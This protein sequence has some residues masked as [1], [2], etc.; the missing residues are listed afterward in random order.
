MQKSFWQCF[1]IFVYPEC[2]PVS[3]SKT[4]LIFSEEQ[5]NV[6][7]NA[8][9][10]FLPNCYVTVQVAWIIPPWCWLSRPRRPQL[11]VQ[12]SAI[13]PRFTS[14]QLPEPVMCVKG[15]VRQSHPHI[16]LPAEQMGVAMT[17]CGLC[18]NVCGQYHAVWVGQS[19]SVGGVHSSSLG[20]GAGLWNRGLSGPTLPT[21]SSFT[22][23]QYN[24]L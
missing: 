19:P 3:A 12:G 9:V 6:T 16:F 13:Y 14:T 11:P 17:I 18:H 22:Q 15:V 10:E 23:L 5:E 24:F 21:P 4:I 8:A 20:F 7:E 1:S 2:P